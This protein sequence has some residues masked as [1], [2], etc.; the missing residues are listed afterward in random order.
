[1]LRTRWAR[2]ALAAG[3]VA[4]LALLGAGPATANP[5]L[6]GMMAPTLD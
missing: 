6:P 4:T 5:Y 2:A 1:M 3:G